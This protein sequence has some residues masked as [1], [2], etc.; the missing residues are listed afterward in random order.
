MNKPK[1]YRTKS[2][3]MLNEART[4]VFNTN[5]WE[6]DPWCVQD[7]DLNNLNEVLVED[8]LKYLN[9]RD[10]TN[11]YIINMTNE[12]IRLLKCYVINKAI[13]DL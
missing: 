13:N 12:C 2:S 8:Y 3:F 6:I 5:G 10:P 1:F 11:D 9:K 7:I 4:H